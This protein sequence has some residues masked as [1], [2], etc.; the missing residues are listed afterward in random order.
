LL[1]S[2][3]VQ[4]FASDRPE[5]ACHALLFFMERSA[6]IDIKPD[7]VPSHALPLEVS[8]PTHP[9]WKFSNQSAFQETAAMQVL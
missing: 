5:F 6:V 8:L 9:S 7:Q 3:G 1:I 4:A 2:F